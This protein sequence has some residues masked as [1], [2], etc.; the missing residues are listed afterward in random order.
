M[1]SPSYQPDIERAARLVDQADCLVIAA[2][3]GMGI[4]SGLPDFRGRHGF[5]R[6]Y[7]ALGRHG[8]AF[9]RIASPHAF[10]REPLL[11][12]GFYGHRLA[13]YRRTMP[14]PGF[15]LLRR[16]ADEMPLGGVVFTSNVDG[17]FQQAGYDDDAVTECHGS[18]HFLQC[19]TPCCQTVW[20][21]DGFVPEID[22]E[23]CLLR[24]EPPACPRCGGCAR[25]NVL[26][27][28]DPD[29]IATRTDVQMRRLERRLSLASRPVV[30]EI[31]AGQAVPTV[32]HFSHRVA[33]E[34]RTPVIRINPREPAVP[35]LPQAVG[36]PLNALEA[37]RA[38][39]AALTDPGGTVPDRERPAR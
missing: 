38:I 12:W 24:N 5:W 7:P 2:G 15:A 18:L 6:A 23:R 36:L 11:A 30:V 4:D 32:R 10:R 20:P 29:W 22:D 21:A 9:P 17:Q 14:H 37:L 1:P 34:R 31:G 8:L 13:L 25:P 27:F 28:D 3:A 33:F 39:D 26:M 19:L 16:W 35:G